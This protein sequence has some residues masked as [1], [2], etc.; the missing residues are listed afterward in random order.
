MF[1]IFFVLIH[2]TS[3]LKESKQYILYDCYSCFQ[4]NFAL[5]RKH[6]YSLNPPTAVN[7]YFY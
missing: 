4:F 6:D 5:S 1:Y 3:S 2:L 7:M